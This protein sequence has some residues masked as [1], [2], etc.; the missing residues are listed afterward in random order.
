M[1]FKETAME[2][3][4][5]IIPI[6]AIVILLQLTIGRLP[7]EVFTRFLGGA[8]LIV[9]GLILF[10][11]GVKIGFLP[12]GEMLGAA[13]VAR[14]KLWLI[15]T[16]GFVIGFVLTI[17]EPDVQV[18][19]MQVAQVSE[20]A[21]PK[22]LLIA[23][24]ALGVAI[25][26]SLALLRVSLNIPLIYL[27]TGGYLLTFALAAFTPPQFLAVAFDA[28]G[29]TTGPMTVPV[30]LALGVG[31]VAGLGKRSSTQDS[32]GWIGLASLGPILAVLLLGVMFQ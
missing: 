18:L 12:M 5:A 17:A 13:I 21:I 15:L 14:G 31:A 29:V 28:G 30:I 25:F 19:A 7:M 6:V 22:N 16:L 27:L 24:V 8:V 23:F 1:N 4:Y 10:F 26:V 9:I 11:I 3:I 20:G 2:V 32:F